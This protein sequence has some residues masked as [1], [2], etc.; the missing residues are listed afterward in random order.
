MVPWI[1]A[2]LMGV[3][4]RAQEDPNCSGGAKRTLVWLWGNQSSQARVIS[5]DAATFGGSWVLK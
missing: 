2:T 4:P 1:Y 5:L 3:S